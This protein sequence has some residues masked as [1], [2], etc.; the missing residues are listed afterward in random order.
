MKT[1]T[2]NSFAW[3]NA[4]A[5]AR[6]GG[7]EYDTWETTDPNAGTIKK[8]DGSL[9]SAITAVEEPV[10]SVRLKLNV[11][12]SKITYDSQSQSYSEETQAVDSGSVQ[13][14]WYYWNGTSSSLPIYLGSTTLTCTV[15]SD[16][17]E[18]DALVTQVMPNATHFMLM[19]SRGVK[20]YANHSDTPKDVAGT[21]YYIGEYALDV[22]TS[23][24]LCNETNYRDFGHE[25]GIAEVSAPMLDS[26]PESVWRVDGATDNGFPWHYL[27]PD[28]YRAAP[29]E[30]DTDEIYIYDAFTEQEDFFKTHGLG[31]LEPISCEVTHELN[32]EW[33]V[34]MEHPM[35]KAEKYKLILEW[36]VL[37]VRGQLYVINRV[38]DNTPFGT[39]TAYAEHITYHMNDIWIYPHMGITQP[40]REMTANQILHRIMELPDFDYGGDAYE[41]WG[42]DNSRYWYHFDCEAQDIEI[43]ENFHDWDDLASGMTCYAAILGGNGFISRFGGELYRNNFYFSIHPRMQGAKDNAFELYL[44]RDLTGITR[45]V[46]LSTF[47][48][49][50][51]V[52]DGYGSFIEYY[53]VQSTM[54]RYMPHGVW[55]SITLS[56]PEAP[57]FERLGRDAAFEFGKVCRPLICYTF[58]LK[59]L[60][61]NSK[62]KGIENL[63]NCRVGDKGRLFDTKTGSWITLEVTRTRINGR[64]GEVLEVQVG[65]TRSFTRPQNY[66]NITDEGFEYDTSANRHQ[67]RDS[68]GVL[69][70]D[71]THTKLM[72]SEGVIP[73]GRV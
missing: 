39:I 37:L 62:F 13:L 14:R 55:R 40:N 70:F 33:S 46:D 17:D 71:M 69:L 61:F 50:L 31:I 59:D 10:T 30:T 73:Y 51:R 5:T 7:Q 9:L 52:Y 67:L 56:Y 18:A 36:N 4:R 8:A 47:A 57:T 64:T 26:M 54:G 11:F 38:V 63:Q 34:I 58:Q 44:D 32:G 21:Y 41:E 24:F 65:N 28:V 23:Y 27:L 22:F 42:R 66:Y 53:W 20:F 43:P 12:Q 49:A 16:T 48:S 19:I 72:Q 29:L 60:R 45:E 3:E 25:D 35:D 68:E 6:V 1:V 15:A 2:Y